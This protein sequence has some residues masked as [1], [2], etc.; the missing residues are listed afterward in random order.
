MKLLPN[1]YLFR[2]YLG[3]DKVQ[4]FSAGSFVP[5]KGLTD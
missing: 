4:K 2:L 1:I 3:D 5:E